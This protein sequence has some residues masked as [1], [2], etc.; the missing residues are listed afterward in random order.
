M[1]KIVD[2]LFG[3]VNIFKRALRFSLFCWTKF[4]E[5]HRKTSVALK[6]IFI[7][8]SAIIL[9][10]VNFKLS[11]PLWAQDEIKSFLADH[12]VL[13]LLLLTWPLVATFIL[14]L[15]SEL[16]E[17]YKAAK[18]LRHHE[19]FTFI[20]AINEVVGAKARRFG[21]YANSMPERPS[22]ESVFATI[23][24]PLNQIAILVERLHTVLVMLTKDNSL[25]VVLARIDEKDMPVEFTVY[26]PKDEVPPKDLLV[27]NA[28]RTLFHKCA[29][30][31]Q[32]IGI[33]DIA[34]E[35]TKKGNK[36]RYAASDIPSDSH[37]SI[38]CHPL[39][40]PFCNRVLFCLSVKSNQ[41]GYINETFREKYLYIID[42][43]AKRILLEASLEMM[44]KRIKL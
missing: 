20:Q 27:K 37:G 42:S 3:L 23:T 21:E 17:V 31:R 18:Q 16:I 4:C 9:G 34:K 6:G 10:Y 1:S 32:T 39:I 36:K 15:T 30:L 7:G 35:L 29:A 41:S 38:I 14:N 24:Q 44:K 28:R 11:K 5:R 26:E 33:E 8:W 40:H 13:V 43:F 25:K 2:Y 12:Y 19:W 22:G